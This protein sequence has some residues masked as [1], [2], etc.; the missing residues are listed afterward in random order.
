MSSM[1]YLDLVEYELADGENILEYP[2]AGAEGGQ[3]VVPKIN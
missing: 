3:G 2:L 1:F